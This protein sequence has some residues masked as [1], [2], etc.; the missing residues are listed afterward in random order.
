MMFI[1][2]SFRPC[3]KLSATKSSGFFFSKNC[4]DPANEN[5]ELEI[6]SLYLQTTFKCLRRNRT[7]EQTVASRNRAIQLRRLVTERRAVEQ[8]EADVVGTLFV[9]AQQDD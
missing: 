9:G 7:D 1:M 2:F 6:F 3:K 8:N 5:V 4:F